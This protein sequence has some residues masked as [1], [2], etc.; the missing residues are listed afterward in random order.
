MVILQAVD[1]TGRLS[2]IVTYQKKI[3]VNCVGIK[4]LVAL[5]VQA[6]FKDGGSFLSGMSRKVR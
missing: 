4:N 2:E 3:F 5:P 6:G 1:V